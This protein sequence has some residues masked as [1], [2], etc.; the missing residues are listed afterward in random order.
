MKT[1][2]MFFLLS[3][4]CVGSISGINMLDVTESTEIT[5]MHTDAQLREEGVDP[6]VYRLKLWYAIQK[7][8]GGTL[9]QASEIAGAEFVPYGRDRTP[10]EV[11]SSHRSGWVL[12]LFSIGVPLWIYRKKLYL[13]RPG[14]DPAERARARAEIAARKAGK[15]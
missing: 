9:E 11:A 15:G 1:L 7:E 6:T 3:V 13:S 4:C 10:G 12:V 5:M 14:S 8:G 2:K